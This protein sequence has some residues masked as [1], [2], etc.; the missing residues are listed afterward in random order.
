MKGDL[1]RRVDRIVHASV[2]HV[3]LPRGFRKRGVRFS[4]RLPELTWLIEIQRG[5]WSTP[6]ETRFTIN[7]GV[8]IPGLMSVYAGAQEQPNPRSEHWC[9]AVR[10]GMLAKENL[11]TWWNLTS[12]DDPEERDTYVADDIRVRIQR[13]LLPFMNEMQ[14]VDS[15]ID[16]LLTYYTTGDCRFTPSEIVAGVYA[17]ILMFKQGRKREGA[18]T[19]DAAERATKIRDFGEQLQ[20]IRRRLAT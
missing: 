7:C 5:R 18:A 6:D 3:L 13:D 10:L 9:I 4:K 15:A 1:S 20:V 14:D 12:D 19:L 2:G 11:D 8:Y 16:R 17:A